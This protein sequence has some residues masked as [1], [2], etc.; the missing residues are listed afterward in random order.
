[1]IDTIER[2]E[3]WV[4]KRRIDIVSKN[5]DRF[6]IL[7][8]STFLLETILTHNNKYSFRLFSF[9]KDNFYFAII[10]FDEGMVGDFVTL[11]DWYEKNHNEPYV[12]SILK[13]KKFEIYKFDNDFLCDKRYH[14][15]FCDN[16]ME[17][18]IPMLRRF[19]IE[20]LIKSQTNFKS[21]I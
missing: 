8:K 12:T 17:Q 5:Y 2:L 16:E 1:M 7:D 9:I 3:R 11:S 4:E 14:D 10:L 18:I 20:K 13:S 6:Y 15:E 21:P 19:K